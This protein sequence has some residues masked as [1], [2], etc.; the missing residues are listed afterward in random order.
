MDSREQQIAEIEAILFSYG[1]P[2]SLSSIAYAL[3]VS[4][5]DALEALT[6]LVL[7]YKSGQSGIMLRR[8]GDKFQMCTNPRYGQYIE[9]VISIP[10]PAKLTDTQMQVLAFIAYRQPVTKPEIDSI[11]GTDSASVLS[12]L[13][14]MKLIEE[15]GRLQKKGC[16]ISYGTTDEFLSR[17][18]LCS[19]DELPLMSFDT[20]EMLLSAAEEEVNKAFS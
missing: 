14:D 16:P 19:V 12:R 18:N 1:D 6:D 4:E 7:K 10:K 15:K 13:I 8:I 3:D 5:E 2:V 9:K 17:F 20:R 11:R